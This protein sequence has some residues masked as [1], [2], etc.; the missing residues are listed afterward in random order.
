MDKTITN[1]F[2]SS[3]DVMGTKVYSSVDGE[4]VGE[5]DHLVIDKAS[6]KVAYADMGYGGFL[7]L[8]EEHRLIPWAKLNYQTDKGGYVTDITAESLRDAPHWQSGREHD[9]AWEQRTFDH[10]GVPYYWL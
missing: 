9:R 7:G 3:A 5:I 6:G 4:K 2:V 1:S 8:G 10:Y